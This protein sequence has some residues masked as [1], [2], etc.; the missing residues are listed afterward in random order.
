MDYLNQKNDYDKTDA[1]SI[2]TYAKK[3]IDKSFKKV[4]EDDVEIFIEETTPAVFENKNYKGGLGTLIEKH[5]FHYEPNSDSRPDFHEAGV[6]LKVSPFKENCNGTYSAKERL[7]ITQIN[8][9][10]IIKESFENSHLWAK[11]KLIL[12]VYYLWQPDSNRLDYIIK[13]VS[14]FSPSEEDL[15]IIKNDYATIQN[16]VKKGLA[17]ELSGSDTLYLEACTKAST[18]KD[19]RPQPNSDI[20]AKPRS[21]AFKTSYMTY[22]LNNYII[23]QQAADESII[24]TP[25]DTP[26]EK[27]IEQKI[28]KYIGCSIED[29]YLKFNF[30]FEK[31][32]KNLEALIAYRILG[33]KGNKASEFQKAGIVVKSIR[34]GKNNKIKE[35]MSFPNFKFTELVKETWEESTFRNYLDSTRFFFIVYKYDNNDV[36]RLQ[37]CQFWNIPYSDLEDDVKHVWEKTCQVIREGIEVTTKNGKTYNN[38]P[39]PSENRVCHVRPHGKN[40]ED[41]YPLPN[42][43]AFTKQCFWLNNS[44]ILEQLSDTLKQ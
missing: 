3:L 26:F 37:G 2:E 40:K 28:S 10:N 42:G 43:K 30:S 18:S 34:I 44:Y 31:K 21:F 41:T 12:L 19:R 13:Y 14:L 29:L 39:A 8:Y 11:A 25:T 15:K 32:P 23:N 1:K 22:V 16:K 6:E 9:M 27:Y 17:H 35:H 20:P 5:H 24:K 38:L 33:I 36:L 7:S 4:L